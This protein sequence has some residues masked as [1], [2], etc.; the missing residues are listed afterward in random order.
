MKESVPE[1]L[2]LPTG[3]SIH[4]NQI[5]IGEGNERKLLTNT[6]VFIVGK[7]LRLDDSCSFIK[8][9]ILA[10][11]G[12]VRTFEDDAT[13]FFE[14]KKIVTLRRRGID[15][16]SIQ[17]RALVEYFVAFERQNRILPTF[18]WTEAA[19]WANRILVGL[20]PSYWGSSD[21]LPVEV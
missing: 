6:P 15:T 11:D 5:W 9:V 19:E 7:K 12:N 20:R 17:A 4:E 2:V 18:V 14:Q 10:E 1:H 3:Y 13:L 21:I 8:V 16:N